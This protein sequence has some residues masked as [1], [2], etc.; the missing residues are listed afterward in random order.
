MKYGVRRGKSAK[1]TRTPATLKKREQRL[2]K[3]KNRAGKERDRKTEKFRQSENRRV[4]K[5]VG[6][7]DGSN[8]S[9]FI[10]A[11]SAHLYSSRTARI[12]S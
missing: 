11:R 5:A 2:K 9:K 12:R 3:A 6:I 4:D 7:D 8:R 10:G 1:N